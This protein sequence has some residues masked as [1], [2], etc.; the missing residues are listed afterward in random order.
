MYWKHMVI[1]MVKPQEDPWVTKVKLDINQVEVHPLYT[2][3]H[4]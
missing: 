1:G 2:T 3:K 4:A